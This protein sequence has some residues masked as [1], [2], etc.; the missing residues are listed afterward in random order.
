MPP[1]RQHRSTERNFLA[2]QET[3]HAELMPSQDRIRHLIGNHHWQTDGEHKEE[4]LRSVLRSRLPENQ[5]IGKGFVCVPAEGETSKKKS[6]GQIDILITPTN[7]LTLYRQGDLVFVTADTSNAIIEVKTK[8]RRQSEESLHFSVAERPVRSSIKRDTNMSGVLSVVKKLSDQ[9]QLVRDNGNRDWWAGLFVYDENGID[10]SDVLR[11]VQIAARGNRRRAINC[12]SVGVS[13]FIHYW[14]NGRLDV[15]SPIDGAVWHSYTIHNLAPAYFVNNLAM[16]FS[17][18]TPSAAQNMW[19]PIEG[20]KEI[21]RTYY[22][23]L[24]D[25]IVHSF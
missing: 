7:G 6:S 2:L 4:L 8:V 21:R 3:V 10:H 11:A 13:L 14:P 17:P 12:V 1:S 15:N 20:S 22:A 25:H 16:H 23:A 24:S 5:R 18:Q 9:I 19:F